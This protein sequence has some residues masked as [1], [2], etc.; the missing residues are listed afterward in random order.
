M[1]SFLRLFFCILLL[2]LHGCNSNTTISAQELQQCQ[3]SCMQ[4]F[5]FCKKNCVNNCPTC[6]WESQRRAA[7]NYKKYVNEQKIEGKQ[8]MRELNSY[9]DPLQ[10]LKVTCNCMA[11]F[12]ACKQSCTGGVS[13]RLSP[14]TNCI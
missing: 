2:V 4:H 1:N 14:V 7:N 10:C 13:K 12:M 5:D 9:R 3:Q 8:I 6:S 11:D